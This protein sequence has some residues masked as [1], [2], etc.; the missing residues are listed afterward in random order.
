MQRTAQNLVTVSGAARIL[1]VSEATIRNLDRR[2]ILPASRLS[3]GSRVF[4]R[5]AL[6]LV[7][8]SRERK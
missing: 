6:E 8:V 7:K 2:G 1:K 3:N 4:E 5:A